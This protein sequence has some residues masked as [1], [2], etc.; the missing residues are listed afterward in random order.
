MRRAQGWLN[1]KGCGTRRW[2]G[3]AGCG[4]VMVLGFVLAVGLHWGSPRE[5]FGGAVA[6]ARAADFA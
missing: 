6:L 1:P 3:V 4:R 5:R 2:R